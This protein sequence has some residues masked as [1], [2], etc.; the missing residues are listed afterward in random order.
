VKLRV[1]P[2]ARR[3]LE[4]IAEYLTERSPAASRFAGLRIRETMRLLT[5]F[6]MIGHEGA[7]QGTREWWC[8]ACLTSLF[9]AWSPRH[10][11]QR[12]V[13]APALG[14][15][16]RSS[17]PLGHIDKTHSFIVAEAAEPFA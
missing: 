14:Q 2:Q 10:P 12:H 15:Q 4:A 6:P 7:L 5:D 3:H 11:P 1:T 13:D 8:L 17:L 9:I 16:R